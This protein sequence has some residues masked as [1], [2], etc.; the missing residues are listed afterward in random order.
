MATSLKDL[1]S[2][3]ISR[4]GIG[5]Q[6]TAAVVCTEFDRIALKIL[7]P[8]VQD[9]LKAMY[10]KNST[11][12]VAVGSSSVGQEIKLHEL[13]ILEE[14]NKKVGPPNVERLRFLV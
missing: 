5:E 2:S 10:V 1:L 12:T 9:K 3:S 14:L 8:A 11:L 13:E 7:G 6:V 4:A